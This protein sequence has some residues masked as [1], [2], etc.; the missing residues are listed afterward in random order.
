ML[1]APL[2]HKESFVLQHSELRASTLKAL[3]EVLPKELS[4]ANLKSFPDTSYA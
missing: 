3:S 1:P 2:A 4:L